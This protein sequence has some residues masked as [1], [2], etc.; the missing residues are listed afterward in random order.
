MK[1]SFLK[2]AKDEKSF[3]LFELLGAE[4]YKIEDLEKTDKVIKEL[5]KKDYKTMVVTND[6]AGF[7]ELIAKKNYMVDDIRIIIAPPK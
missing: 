3:R 6:V 2:S 4:T 1:I 5:I 7:S